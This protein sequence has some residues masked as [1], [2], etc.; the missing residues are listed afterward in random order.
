VGK[1]FL[2]ANLAIALARAGYRVVAIDTSQRP[3]TTSA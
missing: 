1:T 3:P 2:S